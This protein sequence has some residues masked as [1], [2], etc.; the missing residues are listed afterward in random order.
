MAAVLAQV[1]Y[2]LVH[3]RRS[4]RSTWAAYVGMP[5][6]SVDVVSPFDEAE[7]N[8][9]GTNPRTGVRQPEN[10]LGYAANQL[11]QAKP[12]DAGNPTLKSTQLGEF[13]V[14]VMKS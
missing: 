1:L 6:R 11:S 4:F 3:Q 13:V 8:S 12:T 10:W 2:C 14:V 7:K 5:R 9:Q